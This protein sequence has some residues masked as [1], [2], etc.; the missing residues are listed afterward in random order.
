VASLKPLLQLHRIVAGVKHKKWWTVSFG[1][2]IEQT[3]DLLSGD[4]VCVLARMDTTRLHRG[5]PAV[6]LEAQLG[7]ELVGPPRHNRL[8]RRV[9]RGMVIVSP[10]G[11]GLGVATRPDAHVHGVDGWFTSGYERMASE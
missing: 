2:P 5:N 11:A 10:L 9:A 1:Q 4:L 3:L 8:P 7:D 6:A